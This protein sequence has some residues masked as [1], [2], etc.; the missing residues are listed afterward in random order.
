[1]LKSFNHLNWIITTTKN[2]LKLP[3]SF[4]QIKNLHQRGSR[5]HCLE[6]NVW[7]WVRAQSA[8]AKNHQICA[9][10]GNMNLPSIFSVFDV[11]SII[12][13]WLL[14]EQWWSANCLQNMPWN[15]GHVWHTQDWRVEDQVYD[16][17]R[18]QVEDLLQTNISW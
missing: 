12:K 17:T 4:N 10:D 1:M 18:R 2:W 15:H 16:L 11:Y 13:N 9:L 6:K 5:L 14:T 7:R 8:L 3:K